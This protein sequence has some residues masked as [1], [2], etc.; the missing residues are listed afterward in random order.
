MPGHPPDGLRCASGSAMPTRRP[1][2]GLACRSRVPP[3]AA[4][5]AATIDRPSPEPLSEP[6]RSAPSR[7]NGWA[8]CADLLL[9]ED[10]PAGL[11][12]Q[13]GQVPVAPGGDADPAAV[14]VVRD[15]V[16]DHVVHHA[17]Q[18]RLAARHPGAVA[19]RWC[20]ARSGSWRRSRPP[21][22]PAPPTT[23]YSSESAA[24][25]GR[26]PCCAR[27][28]DQEAVEQ[29][30]DPVE[31]GA[32][33]RR[34][35][36]RSAPAPAPAWPPPRPRRPA[37]WSAA[38]AA[39]A[40]RW[41]RTGAARR[42]RPP[43]APA[44]RRWCRRDPSARPPGRARPAARAGCP[45]RSAGWPRSSPAAG[46]APGRRR[47][48]RATSDTHGHDGQRDRR[49]DQERVRDGRMDQMR[50]LGLRLDRA[51]AGPARSEAAAPG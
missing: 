39:R 9:V 37:S 13:A 51:C 49:P 40:R 34:P 41:R 24:W 17:A 15:R 44:A 38:C 6:V 45:R 46:A 23:T 31:L 27:A 18:Q 4:A 28:S 30:V 43:A 3:W 25:P 10:V 1:P 14:V 48:S 50:G 20:G 29:P 32:Q 21:A 5:M 8:S 11:H 42:T 2:P 36:R 33:P 26:S 7:R 12:H 22:R 35:G 19:G 47:S 16:V